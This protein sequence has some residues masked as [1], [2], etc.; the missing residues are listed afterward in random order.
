MSCHIAY[1]TRI[2]LD[3]LL[4]QDMPLECTGMKLHYQ[5]RVPLMPRIFH[6]HE[7]IRAK[8]PKKKIEL[9]QDKDLLLKPGPMACP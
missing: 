3:F 8:L 5:I 7:M 4:Y 9:S 6:E 1:P 2:Y